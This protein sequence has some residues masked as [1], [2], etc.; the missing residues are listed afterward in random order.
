MIVYFFSVVHGLKEF[1]ESSLK[2]YHLDSVVCRQFH[3]KIHGEL[4]FQRRVPSSVK[5]TDD[6]GWLYL[7]NFEKTC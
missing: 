6:C 1:S 5:N 3:I 4:E 7:N 2:E